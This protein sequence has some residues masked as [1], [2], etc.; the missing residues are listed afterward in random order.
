[1]SLLRGVASWPCITTIAVLVFLCNPQVANCKNYGILWYS[2]APNDEIR[3][4]AADRYDVGVSGSIGPMDYEKQLIVSMNPS[5]RWYVYNSGT[6]NYV[7]PNTAGLAEY[8]LLNSI[9]SS[10]GWNP[11]IAYL[12][13]YEDT[14][15]NLEGQILLIPGWGGGSA[16]SPDQARVPVYYKNLTR[17]VCNFSTP[18]SAQLYREVMVQLAFDA[19]FQGTTLYADGIFLDNTAHMLYNYGTVLS[20]GGVREAPNHAV[21]GSPEFR[22]WHWNQN[23]GPFLTSLK[24]TL[25]TGASWAKDGKRK[26]LMINCSNAWADSYVTF[27]AADVLFMEF[28]YNPVR[29]FG[30]GAIDEAYRRDALAAEAGI[31]CFYS[32]TMT[33]SVA[34]HNGSYSLEEIMLGNLCWFLMTRTPLTLFYQQGTN[35]PNTPD[36]ETLTWI[37][38][39]DVAN[40]E[41]GEATGTCYTLAQGTDALGNPYVVKARQYEHGLVVLRNRGDWDEGIEPE[42]AVSVSLPGSLYPLSPAGTTGSPVS[43]LSLRN[44]QGA[45]LMNGPVAVTLLS[46]TAQRDVEGAVLHWQISNPTDHAGFNI[47]REDALGNRVRLN[48]TLLTGSLEYTFIDPNPPVTQARY[49]LE[50]LSRTGDTRWYGPALLDMAKTGSELLLAQNVPNP[51]PTGGSTVIRFTT[52]R[53]GWVNV[54]IYDLSGRELARLVDAVLPGGAHEVHWNGLDE[55]G[56]SVGAGMYYYRV[57][58]DGGDTASRKLVVH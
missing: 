14:Q 47:A 15:V 33:R 37:G 56:R 25:E 35:A 8:N 1:M 27:D 54:G 43:S 50:E 36:W 21:I 9:C 30:V 22:S 10:R 51:V 52:A 42:T 26:Y 7:P 45:I 39:M 38:A 3:E 11:E 49:W 23:L 46:F 53:E 48:E 20:G 13:Y 44:G 31:A 19:P 57:L 28:E 32:A 24:D 6:D 34:G 17:R 5:F 16:T 12:H 2:G 40:N 55:R 4:I 29:S 41:L 18:Q 58:T